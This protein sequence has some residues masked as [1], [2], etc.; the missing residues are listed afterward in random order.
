MGDARHKRRYPRGPRVEMTP[1]W[2]ALVRAKL[3]GD[4]GWSAQKLADA[5]GV[6]KSAIGK[7]LK[8]EQTAS[9]I[10]VQVS[11]AL[12]IPTPTELKDALAAK[13]AALPDGARERILA[14]VEWILATKP[15]V[16]ADL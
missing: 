5:V 3:R 8:P 2:K 11:R 10:V 4:N 15:I 14:L 7:M 13:L 6:H 16:L 12:E 9:A 1:Q